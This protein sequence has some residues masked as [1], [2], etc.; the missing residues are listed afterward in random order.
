MTPVGAVVLSFDGAALT[1]DC[2]ESLAGEDALPI[3]VDNGS[4]DGVLERLPAGVVGVRLASNRGFSAGNNAGVDVALERGC[5]YVL[6]LN[7]DCVVEPG[8][9]AAL[10]AA[11]DADPSVGAVSPLITF[12]DAPS[13]VWYGGATFDPARGRPGRMLG[14]RR[15]VS[16]ST[17][18]GPVD[19]FSG[20]AVMLRA[21]AL[22]SVGLLDPELFFLYEDVDWSLRLRAAGWTLRLEPGAR[23]R[24]RVAATQGGEHSPASFYYGLRNQL[25]VCDRHAP[26][27]RVGRWRRAAVAL[28]AHVWRAR[29]AP[30]RVGAVAASLEGLRDW[31]RGRLGARGR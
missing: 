29:R 17:V 3:V 16:A 19:R 14:Y 20:A 15:R 4:T 24:H 8:A 12:A 13:M 18:A 9:V 23:V 31:R 2:L 5:E 27:G 28:A 22:R 25:V 1:L 21:S 10:R 11:L 6:V 7:N 30:R 26:L